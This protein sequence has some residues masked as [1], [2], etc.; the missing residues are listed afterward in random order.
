MS[1]VDNEGEFPSMVGELKEEE[2][3]KDQKAPKM[4]F[5]GGKKKGRK[6]RKARESGD[7]D[8]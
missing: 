6:P 2:L 5:T 7:E 1:E 8:G 4:K 3:E